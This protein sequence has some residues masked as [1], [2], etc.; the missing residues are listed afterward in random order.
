MQEEENF[1][2]LELTLIAMIE[3]RL[4]IREEEK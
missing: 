4:S 1:S 2:K 3:C